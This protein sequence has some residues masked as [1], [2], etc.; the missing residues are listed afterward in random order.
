MNT[1]EHRRDPAPFFVGYL[2]VPAGLRLFLA[3]VAAFLIGGFAALAVSIGATREDPGAAAFHFDWGPQTIVGVLQAKPYPVVHVVR[4][5]DRIPAGRT[6]MLAGEGKRGEQLRAAALDGRMVQVKGIAIRRGDLD[7]VQ[8]FDGAGD[9][10]E[11]KTPA[12]PV[13]VKKQGRWRLAGEI[14]DGKCLAGA[15]RPGRGMS[16]RACANLCLIGGLPPVFMSS[17]PIGGSAYLLLA[18]SNGEPL[19]ASVLDYVALY[20]AV[21]GEVETRGS[22]P[23]F[24]IDLAS[25]KVL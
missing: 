23:V 15:M 13:A 9:F 24:K 5:S 7:A 8:V 14:C 22:M 21:E 19:P 10:T 6:V 3:A 2:P 12:Q 4:G 1:N 20:V 17:K 18:D 16:H 25:L 11:A